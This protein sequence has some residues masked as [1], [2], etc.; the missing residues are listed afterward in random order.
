MLASNPP[1]L[2]IRHALLTVAMSRA[3]QTLTRT[4]AWESN[5]YPLLTTWDSIPTS[6]PTRA[7]RTLLPAGF[8][9]FTARSRRSALRHRHPRNCDVSRKMITCS[10]PHQ[11]LLRLSK[12]GSTGRA[13]SAWLSPT[14]TGWLQS[15]K[16]TASPS[17]WRAGCAL[18]FTCFAIA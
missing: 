13:G 6:D 18:C 7:V 17:P 1:A 3:K 12:K 2:T 15:G 16:P 14:M 9:A 4:R 11:F 10:A 5:L 8:D